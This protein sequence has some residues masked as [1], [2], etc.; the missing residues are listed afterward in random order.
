V[1]ALF[2]VKRKKLFFSLIAVVV[3][4]VLVGSA[5]AAL[6]FMSSSSPKTTIEMQTPLPDGCL[7]AEQA[8]QTA[9]N[10]T[11]QYATQNNRTITEIKAVFGNSTH[12]N[13]DYWPSDSEINSTANGLDGVFLVW[14]VTVTFKESASQS[15]VNGSQT[16]LEFNVPSFFVSIYAYSGQLRTEGPIITI[17]QQEMYD[18]QQVVVNQGQGLLP[19]NY[20]SATQAFK[21]AILNITQYITENNRTV[22]KSIVGFGYNNG[23]PIW[24]F[25]ADFSGSVLDAPDGFHPELSHIYGYYVEVGADTAQIEYYHEIVVF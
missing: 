25:E 14:N 12:H 17:N 20:I 7:T 8:I 22:N 4:A 23:R 24:S 11:N 3:C 16:I 10:Y 5:M 1:F 6:T 18:S 9:K 2:K 15:I 19:E 13:P 21:I